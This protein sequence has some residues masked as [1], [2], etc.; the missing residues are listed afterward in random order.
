M[1]LRP[2]HI[3]LGYVAGPDRIA[4]EISYAAWLGNAVQYIPTTAV[5]S[6]FAIGAPQPTPFQQGDTVHLGFDLSDVR[7]VKA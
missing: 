5:G 4:A 1:V 7:L 2:H 3:W 6:I